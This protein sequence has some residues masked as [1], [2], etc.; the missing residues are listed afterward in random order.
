[1]EE[2]VMDKT[3]E[4]KFGKRI[5]ELRRIK[6]I[7]QQDLAT[8]LG[9]SRSMIAKVESGGRIGLP[10]REQITIIANVLG[11]R[12]DSLLG[13]NEF[14]LDRLTQEEQE[15]LRDE[16]STDY[17][18]IAL[19]KMREFDNKVYPPEH[20]DLSEYDKLNKEI[21]EENQGRLVDK[22]QHERYEKE[23]SRLF[24]Y[25]Y[26]DDEVVYYDSNGQPQYGGDDEVKNHYYLSKFR[27]EKL[28]FDNLMDFINK[29]Y[30]VKNDDI[31]DIKRTVKNMKMLAQARYDE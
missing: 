4:E 20:Q 17:I 24:P 30:G 2:Y 19:R 15:L 9:L 11:V 25:P 22:N 14:I 1:M 16:R 7:N 21:M 8:A 29:E 18:K 5:S 6:G 28:K 13:S 23:C 26:A 10:S 12:V 27:A 3:A 31:D